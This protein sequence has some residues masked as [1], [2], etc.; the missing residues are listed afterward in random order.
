MFTCV[1]GSV[2][3]RRTDKS[4]EAAFYP[5]E[6]YMQAVEE[7]FTQL[8]LSQPVEKRRVYLASDDLNILGEARKK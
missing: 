5:L 2:H 4:T 3:I 6:Q 1:S 7:Y 8:E